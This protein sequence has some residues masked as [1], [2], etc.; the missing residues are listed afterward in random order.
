MNQKKAGGRPA[1]GGIGEKRCFI[2]ILYPVYRFVK[3][4]YAKTTDIS[5]LSVKKNQSIGE[6]NEKEKC[7]N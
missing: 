2:K 5:I 3:R 1:K 6:K 4:N 7:W